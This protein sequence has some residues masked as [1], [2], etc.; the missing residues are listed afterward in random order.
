VDKVRTA[1]SCP[2]TVIGE[3]VADKIGAVTL[4]D[5]KGNPFNLTKVGWE[6]FTLR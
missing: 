1:A 4:V 5:S 3:I 6:H 2:I